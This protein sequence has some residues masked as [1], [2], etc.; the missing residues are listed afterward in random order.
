V[1]HEGAVS[2]WVTWVVVLEDGR[3]VEQ[4]APADLLARG[5]SYAHYVAAAQG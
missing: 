1:V 2:R 3:I 5:G 4:G